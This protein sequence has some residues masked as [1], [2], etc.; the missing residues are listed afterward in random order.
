[1]VYKV[2]IAILINYQSNCSIS[3]D[4]IKILCEE[5]IV[6]SALFDKIIWNAVE[7]N[8]LDDIDN[9]SVNWMIFVPSVSTILIFAPSL[10]ALVMI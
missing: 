6:I 1:M 7:A 10:I 9:P 3:S 2:F 4:F 8:L 5:L